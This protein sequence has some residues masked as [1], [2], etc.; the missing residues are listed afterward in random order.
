MEAKEKAM[1]R[2]NRN[3]RTLSVCG[4]GK[5]E[6]KEPNSCVATP[7]TNRVSLTHTCVLVVTLGKLLVGVAYN[8]CVFVRIGQ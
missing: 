1:S 5:S 7:E 3:Y 4:R 6:V 8:M 2:K